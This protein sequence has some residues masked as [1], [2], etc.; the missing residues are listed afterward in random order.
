M[1]FDARHPDF[2]PSQWGELAQKRTSV[3]P[4]R[5]SPIVLAKVGEAYGT[6]LS[7]VHHALASITALPEREMAALLGAMAQIEQL[8]RLGMQMQA[9]SRVLSGSADLP[10]ETIDLGE[11]ARQVLHA[12]SEPAWAEGITLVAPKGSSPIEANA[13]VV[14]QMLELAVQYAMHVG[15]RIEVSIG[16][17]ASL[18]T[19]PTLTIK[20]QRRQSALGAVSDDEYDALHWLLLAMLAKSSG[21]TAQRIAVAG[22]LVLLL[23]FAAGDAAA[24][25]SPSAALLPRTS[26]VVDRR[27]LL[28]DPRQM[29][30][31]QAHRL[32]HEA[33][34]KVDA[35]A[36]LDQARGSFRDGVPDVIVTGIPADDPECAAMLEELRERQPRL[37]VIELV[38][39]DTAFAFSL[40]GV[41][42]AARVGRHDLPRTLM[43]AIAQELDAAWNG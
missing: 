23:G 5:M 15:S 43:P 28:I 13:S 29:P 16:A 19:Q 27:V 36:S 33:G 40:P 35:V 42:N 18:D 41:S 31:V 10:T 7:Q 17:P 1:S 4:A 32:M 30:R 38:D 9:L 39:D 14:E 37:R 21:L 6:A 8:K 34:M 2:R 20:V 11:A 12:W 22:D 3:M 24:A 25:A 26:S